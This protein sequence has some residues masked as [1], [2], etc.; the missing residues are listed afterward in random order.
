MLK[1]EVE[2]VLSEIRPQLQADGGNVELVE[3]TDDNVVKVKLQGAC[4]GCPMAQMTLKNGIERILKMKIP[5]I[6]YVE[7]V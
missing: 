6:K 7:S 5:G 4:A 1:E 2:K 3:V